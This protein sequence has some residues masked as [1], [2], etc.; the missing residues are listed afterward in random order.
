[1][2]WGFMTWYGVGYLVEIE[3]RMNAHQYVDILEKNLLPGLEEFGLLDEDLIYQQDNDPKYT[4][5]LATKWFED[6]GIM[7]LDWPAQSPDLNPIEHL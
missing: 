6:H 5:K 4:S 1:M 7:V 3:G 2:L